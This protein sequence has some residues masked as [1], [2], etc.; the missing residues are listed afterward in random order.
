MFVVLSTLVM[1]MVPL[2][3]CAS[4]FVPDVVVCQVH[5]MQLG[6]QQA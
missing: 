4:V 5:S 1:V 2:L 3:P 6:G